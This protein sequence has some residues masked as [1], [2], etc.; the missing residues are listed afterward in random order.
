M[1]VSENCFVFYKSLLSKKLQNLFLQ[2]ILKKS[3][4]L[5]YENGNEHL[6][7]VALKQN[8]ISSCIFLFSSMNL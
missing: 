6:D 4:K 2:Y 7:S 5:T 1:R 3:E 8:N